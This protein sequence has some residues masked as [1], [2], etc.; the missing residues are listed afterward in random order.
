V[1]PRK[2]A[3]QGYRWPAEW[4]PHEATW[5]SWP[6]NPD[7]WPGRLDR[8]IDGFVGIVRA[9]HGFERVNLLVDSPA[10]ERVARARL[11]TGGL[12]P[13]ANV[14]F[15]IAPTNDAWVRDYG[16]IFVVREEAGARGRAVID[17]GYDAWGGKYPPWD[18][19]DAIPAQIAGRLGLPCFGADFVLEGGSIDGNGAGALLTTETCLLHPNRG[20]GRTREQMEERLAAWLGV[21]QVLWLGEGIAGDDTDGHIDDIARF[22]DAGTVVAAVES[23]PHDANA[24]PLAANLRRLRGMRDAAGKPLAVATLPMPPPL[25]VAGQRCPA[26]YAN[27]YLGNGVALVPTFGASSDERA[28]AVLREVLPGREIVG[29]RCDELVYGLGAIHC[30]SQQEPA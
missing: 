21:T 19:D 18:R 6:K 12:P 24:A 23:D 27:F 4:E 11:R 25:H 16:P 20:R 9:L 22:V 5:L 30:L 13:D 14:A 15:V 2:P 1:D 28:L 26:S 17:F 7:T 29:V 10:M 8:A 3:A